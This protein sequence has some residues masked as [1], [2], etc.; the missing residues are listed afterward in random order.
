L[1]TATL[2]RRVD[3]AGPDSAAAPEAA[4]SEPIAAVPHTS[5]TAASSPIDTTSVQHVALCDTFGHAFTLADAL[6][7]CIDRAASFSTLELPPG[8]YELHRQLVISKP[9]TVTTAGDDSTLS[10]VDRP[11]RCAILI[12]APDLLVDNGIVFVGSTRNVTLEHVV[13]DGNRAARQSSIAAQFCLTGRTTIG[14]NAAILECASCRLEDVVSRNAL[15][16]SALVWSGRGALIQHSAF[17]DNGD[18]TSAGMWADGLT[19]LYAPDSEVRVNQFV[20]NSDV[21]LIMGYAV[22]SRI[23]ENLVMQATQ[24]AFAGIMLHNFGSDDVSFRGDFRD[25]VIT[26]NTVD[27]GSQLCVFGIQVGPRPWDVTR[28]VVGGDVH[29]NHVRGAKI[30][31][32]AD[33]AG[34]SRAQTRIFANDVSGVPAGE[35]FG[36]CPQPI[37]TAWMNIAPTSAV[38]RHGELIETASQLS[39]RCELS[40][41]PLVKR[42]D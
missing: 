20:N 12:A 9:I 29:Q 35:F 28:N 3:I 32:N 16:G 11:D 24:P 34:T 37:P 36:S 27:C 31:I 15:C 18:A 8:V 33:G 17:V 4:V 7:D 21:A 2:P 5:V 6:Q 41:A 30:G 14:F 22:R 23:E 25:A 38:D 26:D 10:C 19:L 39:E 42:P 13:I 1:S 40:P